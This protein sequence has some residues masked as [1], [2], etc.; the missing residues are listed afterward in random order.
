M[1]KLNKSLYGLSEAPCAWYNHMVKGLQAEGFKISENDPC[2]YIHKN[3]VAVSW[4]DDVIVATTNDSDI[5][6]LVNRLKKRGYE[7]DVEC[8]LSAYLGLDIKPILGNDGKPITGKGAGYHITQGG[9]TN[10][11]IRYCGLQ[12]SN[13]KS[14][15]TDGNPLGKDVDGPL[16]DESEFEYAAAV[17]M[18]LYLSN[19]TRP[20]ITMAVS[21][22]ARF[23]H[24]PRESH[25]IAVKRIVR[26]LV[27]TA[28]KGIIFCPNREDLGLDLWC[29]ADWAGQFRADDPHDPVSAK[30]RSGYI[31]DLAGCPLLWSSKLQ[32]TVAL[33][34]LE[35]EYHCLSESL[36][37]LIPVRRVVDEL[38]DAMAP[39]KHKVTRRMH[40][41]VFEDNASCHSLSVCPKMT[42]RNRHIA[43]RYHWFRSE[44]ENGSV[45]PIKCAS[46]EQKADGQ[47][48]GLVKEPFEANRKLVMGW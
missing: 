26:Y 42:P 38:M 10:K 2:L 16:W 37:V 7:L 35:S 4:V 12:D 24:A 29:D 9:L 6:A 5:Y 22:V 27:G 21:Q 33:S 34:T 17:G 45:V 40:S 13:A 20:D 30:S 39:G 18:L 44:V 11:V 1:L 41:K 8:E 15:P 32:S 31:L 14:T 46:H 36:R 19:N 23:T 47:T 25:A 48:K 43:V 28:D 3:M